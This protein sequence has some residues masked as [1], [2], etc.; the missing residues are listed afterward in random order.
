[1]QRGLDGGLHF[2]ERLRMRRLPLFH[3]DN[4]IAELALH[5]LGIADL[6]REDGVVELR[7]HGAV[8]RKA[9]FAALVL[10]ARIVGVLLGQLGKVPPALYLLEK[11]FGLGLGGGIGLGVGAGSHLDENVPRAGLLRHRV[12]GLVRV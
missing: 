10:A 2:A 5:D 6:L 4:V 9:Q 11:R 8:L 7:H 3:L 12:F 1:M